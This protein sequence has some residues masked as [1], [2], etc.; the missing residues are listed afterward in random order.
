[1]SQAPLLT[2]HNVVIDTGESRR[3]GPIDWTLSR[4]QRIWLETSAE[5]QFHALAELLSGRL[6]P[7]EGYV[8]EFKPLRSQSDYQI[9][10][11]LILNRSITD[12]LNS[13]DAPSFVWLENR[14]RSVE[15]LLDRL[16]LT[17]Q[18]R[19]S[20]LK[21][22]TEEV[23]AKFVAFRFV[24]SRADLL[25]G[26]EI[27]RGTD[28][29]VGKV[30]EMRWADFPGVV[31]GCADL[32]RLPGPVHSHVTIGIGGEFSVESA[33][34]STGEESRAEEAPTKTAEE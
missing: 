4:S 19:R 27:F 11:S 25:I 8:E 7:F 1:M 16:G 28:K 20:P 12:Y 30:L 33:S 23:V 2:Y 9:R 21:F 17:A 14:R 10:S 22:Q 29:E 3:I 31:V 26:S 6:R 15:V 5:A 18:H 24:T 32:S 34:E 13:S